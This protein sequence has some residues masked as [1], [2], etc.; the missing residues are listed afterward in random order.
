MSGP[1]IYNMTFR[2]TDGTLYDNEKA[3]INFGSEKI[4]FLKKDGT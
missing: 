2:V 4:I 3:I 1:G